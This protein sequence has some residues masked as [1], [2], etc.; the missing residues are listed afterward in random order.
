MLLLFIVIGM[1]F[2]SD[3]IFKIPFDDYEFAEQICSIAL[4]FIIFYGGFETRWSEAKRVAG[5]SILL[6]SVGVV[7][8]ALLTGLFCHYIL[9]F[10]LWEGMLVGAVVSSTDAASVFAVLRSKRLNLKYNTASILELESGSNDP[11]AYM[12]TIVIL[13]IMRG[14]GSPADFAY[15]LFAQVFYGVVLGAIIAVVAVLVLRRIRFETS[16]FDTIFVSTVALI[17]YALPGMIG[18]NGYL[19]TYIVGIVLGNARLP[20]TKPLAHFFDGVTGFAQITL[21]FLL[22]LLAFPSQIPDIIIPAIAIVMF[23]TFIA[24]PIAVACIMLPFKAPLA[25]QAVISWAG[26]RGATSIVFAIMATVDTAYTKNDVFHIVFCIVLISI[27]LQGTF[28]PFVAKKLQMIDDNE[29]VMRTFNDY[30]EE[31]EVQ[32]IKISISKESTWAYKKIKELYLP[33]GL[34]IVMI[35]RGT[36]RVIPSGKSEILPNDVLILS[37]EGFSDDRIFRLNE[38]R[39]TLHHEW[40]GKRISDIAISEGNFIVMIKRNGKLLIP[41]GKTKLHNDDVLVMTMDK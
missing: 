7:V 40:C 21:F 30:S 15:M 5:K 28:L 20:N 9:K 31:K 4:I 39:L 26:F 11:W 33:P 24:R 36:K 8:T 19:S 16:G 12:L 25:Q 37:G 13:S 32:F 29:N 38:L 35:L 10:S 18:G 23:L 3:G 14:S 34:L 41:N 1:L 22:G 2:G 6:S 17:S 27:G